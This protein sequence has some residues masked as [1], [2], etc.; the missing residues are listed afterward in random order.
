M[1]GNVISCP[2]AFHKNVWN[3]LRGS[4]T[5]AFNIDKSCGVALVCPLPQKLGKPPKLTNCSISPDLRSVF[6]I[7][8]PVYTLKWQNM[9]TQ[10]IYSVL[11]WGIYFSIFKSE[12]QHSDKTVLNNFWLG[13]N[14]CNLMD[15]RRGNVEKNCFMKSHAYISYFFTMNCQLAEDL[16]PQRRKCAGMEST[17]LCPVVILFRIWSPRMHKKTD[18]VDA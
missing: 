14:R 16:K 11:L 7:P 18:L 15:R 4:P 17:V 8:F 5:F 1:A 2:I 6:I 12:L 10:I 3:C 13:F 9:K